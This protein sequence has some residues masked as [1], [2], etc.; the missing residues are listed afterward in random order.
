VLVPMLSELGIIG[1]AAHTN[2]N[3][4]ERRSC[5]QA[6][7]PGYRIPY[8]IKKVKVAWRAGRRHLTGLTAGL[9]P[10]VAALISFSPLSQGW[11]F[12]WLDQVSGRPTRGCKMGG[13]RIPR[14]NTP[15]ARGGVRLKLRLA[16]CA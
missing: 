8:E 3:I 16:L 12:G 1:S 15:V 9:L 5:G 10:R 7:G 4:I 6:E 14:S 11:P 2:I 13:L